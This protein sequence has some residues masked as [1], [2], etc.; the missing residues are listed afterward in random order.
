MMMMM[1]E[2]LLEL[3][4]STLL[5]LIENNDPFVTGL[6][7][8]K[9]NWI[10]RA[11]GAIGD[12]KLLWYLETKISSGETEGTWLG[13]LLQHLLRNRSLESLRVLRDEP[14]PGGEHYKYELELE[15]DIF[16]KLT[17]FIEHN[18]NLHCIELLWG[19][20][21]MLSSLALAL[22]TVQLRE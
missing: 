7:I 4:E 14:L 22:S 5:F 12:S 3:N 21:A 11:G 6:T 8:K 1:M 16:H 17:P 2:N 13:D 20:S 10:K 9:S 19:T 15:W 18:N